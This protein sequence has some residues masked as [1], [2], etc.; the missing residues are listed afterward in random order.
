[1]CLVASKAASIANNISLFFFF[2]ECFGFLFECESEL[3]M[4]VAS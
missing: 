2:L 3:V 4:P 1:L